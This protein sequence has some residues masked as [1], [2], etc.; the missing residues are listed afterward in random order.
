ME[1]EGSKGRALSLKVVA[2]LAQFE[3]LMSKFSTSTYDALEPE[4]PS[5]EKDFRNFRRSVKDL[6]RRLAVVFCQAFEECNTP[7][8]VYKVTKWRDILLED[9]YSV[10]NANI[11]EKYVR[12]G[13][14]V[15]IITGGS[16]LKIY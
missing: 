6:E 16:I 4:D 3:A 5:F 9:L 2:V 10:E 14:E 11:S 1:L 8:S 12:L 7:G 13:I 15:T